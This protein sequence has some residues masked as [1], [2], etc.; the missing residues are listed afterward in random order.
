M[1]E[2][3]QKLSGTELDILRQKALLTISE[4]KIGYLRKMLYAMVNFYG[5]IPVKKAYEILTENYGEDISEEAFLDLCEY[6]RYEQKEH[7]YI[8]ARKSITLTAPTLLPNLWTD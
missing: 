2:F 7:F 4:E 5:I 8:L 1:S 6:I 3:P